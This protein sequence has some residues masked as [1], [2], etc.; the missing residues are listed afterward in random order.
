MRKRALFVVLGW[1][2]CLS[3]CSSKPHSSYTG[4][5]V[6][7]EDSVVLGELP[8]PQVPATLTVPK[9]RAD[10]IMNHF[11]DAMDFGDTLRSHNTPF[12]EQ[13]VVNFISLFP[14]GS[15]EKLPVYIGN[16]LL[17]VEKDSTALRIVNEVAE[18][19]LNDSNSPMRDEEYFI[20]FLEE[21]LRLPSLSE[22]ERIRPAQQ[23]ATAKKNRIG[24]TA[25]DFSYLTR[26]GRNQ[27]LHGMSTDAGRMLLVFYDPAC[28]HCSAI[29]EYLRESEVITPLV[30][31]GNLY[32]LA[33]YTEGDSALWDKTK[34]SLPQAWHV[35]YDLS[36]I[37]ENGVYNLPAMPVLYLLDGDKKV[38]LKDPTPGILEDAL[39][40]S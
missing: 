39:A 9:D 22:V 13:N 35:G 27:T 33:V 17:G 26:E 5:T 10:Y 6:A 7:D 3:A 28:D 38:L 4:S 32:V 21:T 14:H 25:T 23:L 40:G 15:E 31:S 12:M 30:E 24:T 2:A 11:W 8:L 29:L 34:A 36:G 18:H 37:V 1:M 16:L 20:I 19:Y